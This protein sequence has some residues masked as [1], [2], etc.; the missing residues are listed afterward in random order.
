MTSSTK[1]E[2]HNVLSCRLRRTEPRPQVTCTENFATVFGGALQLTVRR[3]RPMLRDRCPVSLVM[4]SVY[5]VGVLWPNGWMDQ[6][7]TWRGGRPRPR[8]HCVRWGPSSLT[9][10]GTAVPYF[11]PCLIVA[12]RSPISATAEHL[13][14]YASGRRD[15]HTDTLIAGLRKR[16]TTNQRPAFDDSRMT[17]APASEAAS[18]T[19]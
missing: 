17:K 7:A 9:E 14:R 8:R 12:K 3:P 10:R 2:V 1:P 4:P 13:L 6:D 15:R 16:H 18:I 19:G 11:G 5:N